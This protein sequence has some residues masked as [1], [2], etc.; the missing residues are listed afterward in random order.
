MV[1]FALATVLDTSKCLTNDIYT[2]FSSQ[3][4]SCTFYGS[5]SISEITYFTKKK[6]LLD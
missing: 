6:S 2:N 3:S 5:K 1:Y 4:L